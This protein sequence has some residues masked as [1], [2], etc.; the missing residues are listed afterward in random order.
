M[1]MALKIYI[2]PLAVNVKVKIKFNGTV[3]LLNIDLAYLAARAKSLY[4]IVFEI[5]VLLCI[6]N[7]NFKMA[8]KNS[9][10]ADRQNEHTPNAH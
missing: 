1:R 8:T 9:N 2:W 10:M 5:S 6:K 4:R 7:L 3:K